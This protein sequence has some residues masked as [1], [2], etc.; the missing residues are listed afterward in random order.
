[1]RSK[2]ITATGG[3]WGL[4]RLKIGDALIAVVILSGAV[5]W[6]MLGFSNTTT[7]A[8]AIVEVSGEVVREIQ[9]GHEDYVTVQGILGPVLIGVDPAGIR[10]IDSRCP[11]KLC[12]RMGAIDKTG[13]CIAC[14]PNKLVIR[15]EGKRDVDAVTPGMII[16]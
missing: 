2:N 14:V 10:I 16:R 12:I 1:M 9:L 11:H 7:G 8:T 5:G 13:E 4:K 15:I 3:K 6:L